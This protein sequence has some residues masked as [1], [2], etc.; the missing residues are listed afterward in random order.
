MN[1][2]KFTFINYLKELKKSWVLLLVFFLL[3]AGAG[4][5]YAFKGNDTAS[6]NASLEISFYNEKLANGSTVSPYAS[7]GSLLMS[8]KLLAEVDSSVKEEDLPEYEIKE[9]AQGVFGVKI[10]ADS[11]EK[12]KDFSKTLVKAAPAMIEKA[13][14]DS[15]DYKITVLKDAGKVTEAKVTGTKKRI[16]TIAVVAFGALA[17]AMLIVFIRFDYTAA[18]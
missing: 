13:H 15:E 17:L 3:G 6:F 5:F 1:K 8:K 16:I 2:P 12:V 18:R 10:N 14:G 11:E 9:T 7:I 4:T